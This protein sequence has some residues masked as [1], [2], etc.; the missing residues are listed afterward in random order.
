MEKKQEREQEPIYSYDALPPLFFSEDPQPEETAATLAEPPA[1]YSVYRNQITDEGGKELSDIPSAAFFSLDVV[2]RPVREEN[3][4]V[5]D[6]LALDD[7]VEEE[8]V[9]VKAAAVASEKAWFRL[10]RRFRSP[11]LQL[12][13]EI[14]DFCEFLSP[15]PQEEKSRA[16]AVQSVTDVIKHIW[17][18]CKVEVFGSFK[19]GLYLPTSD[20][21]VV[22]LD[23]KVITPLIGLK[24]LDKA[25]RQQNVG[26]KIQVIKARVPIVKFIERHSE[27]PF[28]ISFDID[29]GPKA[30]DY[31][32]D[33]VKRLPPLRPLCMILKVFLQQR[34]LNEV[35]SGGIGSYA[36]LSMLI[37]HLQ[38]YWGGQHIQ[39][40]GQQREQNLGVLLTSFFEFYGRKLN[41]RDIGVA[42]NSPSN[43]YLKTAKGFVSKDKDYLLS[44]Q[45]PQDPGNDIARN[46]YNYYKVKSAFANAFTIL[47]DSNSIMKLGPNRSILGT[48]IRPDNLLLN[49][50]CVESTGG[51]QFLTNS[52]D[53][54]DSP[55]QNGKGDE[56][57]IVYNWQLMDD[58][59]LPRGDSN[60]VDVDNVFKK[61][62]KKKRNDKHKEKSEARESGKCKE[63]EEE[64]ENG[65]GESSRERGKKRRS[66]EKNPGREDRKSRRRKKIKTRNDD[67]EKFEQQKRDYERFA[68]GL[69]RYSGSSL[70]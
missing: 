64:R 50:K 40:H 54:L 25:L 24:A 19:T 36:L 31:M 45:D 43:F 21:D 3:A 49:R 48:I 70:W 51:L 58:E 41:N 66:N 6:P 46:S 20:V 12:H 17:P 15:T 16:A 69:P 55:F 34:E 18:E 10:G 39:R 61:K 27:I 44:I 47:T 11:M 53:P 26:K 60:L 35:F 52:W 5:F 2:S 9:V 33:A 1:S 29:G 23:S 63:E 30:A 38:I 28:D 7:E 67:Y 32:K 42:C 22:I 13:K 59:P 14:L 4:E 57:N 65:D 56:D 8:P 68:N 62:K 37:A